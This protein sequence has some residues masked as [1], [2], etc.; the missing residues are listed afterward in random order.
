MKLTA[1]P[2]LY[3]LCSTQGINATIPTITEQGIL[4]C[5]RRVTK[6]SPLCQRGVFLSVFT[7][8]LLEGFADRGD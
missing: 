4:F 2:P 1:S 5:Q 8:F 3:L 7:L 6:N